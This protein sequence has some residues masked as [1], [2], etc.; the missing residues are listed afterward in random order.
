MSFLD[1]VEACAPPDFSGYRDFRV[2]GARVG[3]VKHNFARCLEAFPDVFHIGET[4]VDL[5]PGLVGFEARS[6]AVDGVLR[7]LADDGLVPGWRDEAYP[8]GLSFSAPQLF[9]MERA[10]VPLFGVRA[11]GVHLNGFVRQGDAIQMWIGRRSLDK[12]VAPGKLDQIV[13]GGQPAGLSLAANLRKESAEEAGIPPRLADRA[14]P[15]G[16]VS[17]CM[18]WSEGLRHDVLFCYDLELPADFT[19]VNTDGETA[20]FYL[21]PMEKIAKTVEGGD[22]FKF[23]CSLVVIDFLI[24]HGLIAPDHPDYLALLRGLRG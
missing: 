17:Y 19:P 7:R 22:D 15:V 4:S 23:N 9:K 1:R 21:W 13:A 3:R 24:R 5:A 20:E 11:Y 14:R 18:E 10:A 2:D 6:A 16:A 12:P 8:V